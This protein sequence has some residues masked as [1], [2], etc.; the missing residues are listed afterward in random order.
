MARV[1]SSACCTCSGV[2]PVLS[3][4]QPCEFRGPWKITS[5]FRC[6]LCVVILTPSLTTAHTKIWKTIRHRTAEI[7]TR[8]IPAHLGSLM[9]AR[10][11]GLLLLLAFPF[12]VTSCI[13]MQD[14]HASHHTL[15]GWVSEKQ[16]NKITFILQKERS[17]IRA[18]AKL[19]FSKAEY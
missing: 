2:L 14:S 19:Q 8:E 9:R 17:S 4:I 16:T 5:D 1:H 3:H 6:V 11:A 18:D 13:C 12:Y 15:P 10:A 7:S